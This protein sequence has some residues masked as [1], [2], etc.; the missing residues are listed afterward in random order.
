M[1]PAGKVGADNRSNDL[2]LQYLLAGGDFKRDRT[3]GACVERRADGRNN[4]TLDGD[5]L[6]QVAT[7]NGRR[8]DAIDRHTHCGIGPALYDWRGQ[9][10]GGDKRYANPANN[11]SLTL[12]V[13]RRK[14]HVLRGCISNVQF[15]GPLGGLLFLYLMLG[16]SKSFENRSDD[17]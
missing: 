11:Q 12:R 6:H 3:G 1:Q 2:A 5:V 7:L 16:I 13:A 8:S 17:V 10:Y 9:P 15:P 4:A 14:L